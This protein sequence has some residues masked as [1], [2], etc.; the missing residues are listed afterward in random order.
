M[1]S[2]EVCFI[3]IWT[4]RL[5]HKKIIPITIELMKEQIGIKRREF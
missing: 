4:G 2:R 1:E 5:T 3:F